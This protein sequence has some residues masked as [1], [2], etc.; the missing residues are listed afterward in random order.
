M[1]VYLSDGWPS[2]TG[3]RRSSFTNIAS[4]FPS[5]NFP[6]LLLHQATRPGSRKFWGGS[7]VFRHFMHPWFWSKMHLANG[8]SAL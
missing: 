2:L 7:Q 5:P 4:L 8:I 6:V 3:S 1:I